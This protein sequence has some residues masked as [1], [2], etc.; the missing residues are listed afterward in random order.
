MSLEMN[1]VAAAVLTGGI[2]AMLSGFVAGKLYHPET[3]EEP[4]YK[5]ALPEGSGEKPKAPKE[6]SI[7][8]LLASANVEAGKKQT[9]KCAACH[10]FTE[11][12]ADG[13]GP[14]LWGIVGSEPAHV[15]GYSFSDALL[16]L[17]DEGKTWNYTHLNDFLTDPKGYAPGTKMAFAGLRKIDQRADVIAYLRTLSSSPVPLPSKEEIEAVEGKSG[18]EEEKTEA[19]TDDTTKTAAAEAPKAQDTKTEKAATA[20]APKAEDEKAAAAEAPKA[21]DEKAAAAEAPKAEDEKAAAAEAPKAEDEKAAAAEAPKA[22]ESQTA[23][24]DAPKAEEAVASEAP[25]EEAA[26]AAAPPAGEPQSELGKLLANADIE[27]GK[28][29]ARKCTACHTFDEGGKNRVGPNLY[30][31][32]GKVAGEGDGYKFSKAMAAKGAEGYTWTYE[33]LDQYLEN[34]RKAIPG[35]KMTF[36]GLKKEQDRADV[37]AY[38]RSLAKDPPPLPN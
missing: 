7:L 2:V 34:P 31:V 9:S 32:I 27:K 8:P 18:G 19:T 36:P 14:N 29:V 13:V 15:A 30:G 17:K 37:I 4:A 23:S 35:N 11:G 24:T 16:K 10:T 33:H 1:K 28:K 21:E 3:L 12:G 25:K 26:A 38:I 6:E 5:I 20:E 22:E